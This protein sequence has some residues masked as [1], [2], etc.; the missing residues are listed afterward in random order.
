MPGT[1][2]GTGDTTV[3]KISRVPPPP[4]LPTI[5]PLQERILAYPENVI[6]WEE[7]VTGTGLGKGAGGEVQSS[8]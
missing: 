3:H 1:V 5:G 2:L 7:I 6:K 4:H 8:S